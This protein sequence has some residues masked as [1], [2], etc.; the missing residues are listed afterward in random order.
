M[1]KIPYFVA[2]EANYKEMSDTAISHIAEVLV[3]TDAMWVAGVGTGS[4]KLD[5]AVDF[6]AV[7]RD[8]NQGFES[9]PVMTTMHDNEKLKEVV[10]FLDIVTP[11]EGWNVDEWPIIAIRFAN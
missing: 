11:M 3:S 8:L 10:E 5:D 7:D 6:L 2:I 9:A 1:P 4:T